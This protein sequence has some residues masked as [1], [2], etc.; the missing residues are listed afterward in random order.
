[1][2][3]WDRRKEGVVFTLEGHTGASHLS[4]F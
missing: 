2:K 4:C 3:A 1:V